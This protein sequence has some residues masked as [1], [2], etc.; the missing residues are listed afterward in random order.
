MLLEVEDR[1]ELDCDDDD[2]GRL[3]M[4]TPELTLEADDEFTLDRTR[5]RE[6]VERMELVEELSDALLFMSTV[7]A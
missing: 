5:V 2:K 1:E 4:N 7:P 3:L 6:D